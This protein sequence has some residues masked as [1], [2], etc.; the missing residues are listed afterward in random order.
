VLRD[1][2][3]DL[4]K[5]RKAVYLARK[6]INGKTHYF[7][8]E[9][10]RVD[11]FFESRDLVSLGTNPADYIVYPGG[12]GYYIAEA[13]E[14][15]L[16]S[17]GVEPKPDELDEIF[18]CFLKPEIRR[19]VKQ[20]RGRGRRE[21]SSR[22]RN[23]ESQDAVPY[24]HLF[25]KRRV[26]YLKYAQADQR[27]IGRMPLRSFRVL[28]NKS[29]DE[30]EQYFMEQED[31]LR[32]SE[33]KTYV[34]VVFDVQRHFTEMIAKK[35]PQGLDQDEVDTRFLEEVCRLNRERTFWAGMKTDGNLHEY[36]IRYVVMFFDYDYDRS[37]WLRD[38][39]EDFVNSKRQYQ[40]PSKRKR[41]TLDEASTIFGVA[42]DVLAEMNRR[43][44]TRLYRKVAQKL[45]PDKGGDHDAFISLTHAYRDLLRKKD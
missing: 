33:Y 22:N 21:R 43:A 5:W 8:R 37:S 30:L 36:L 9:S 45:H 42:K 11:T 17:C 34:Y 13:V 16:R 39:I 29:R 4:S 28:L 15:K 24:V 35:M 20:F 3:A 32:P 27:N 19:V 38:H 44:L 40:P 2:L 1:F 31:I 25:D 12:N 41:V 14:E 7:I 18:W 26:H 6:K 23:V 10:Y